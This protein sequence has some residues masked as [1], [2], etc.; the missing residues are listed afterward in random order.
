MKGEEE[1]GKRGGRRG[2]GKGKMRGERRRDGGKG[3]GEREGEG[4]GKRKG[5]GGEGGKGAPP[6]QISGSAPGPVVFTC[7][8]T[9]NWS[10]V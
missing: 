2:E 5:T 4:K 7:H 3:G 6:S 1:R 8:Q 9:I 10:I